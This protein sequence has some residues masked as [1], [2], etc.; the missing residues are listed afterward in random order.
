MT[1][2]WR[3]Q[4]FRN[5]LLLRFIA[6]LAM[7]TT[8]RVRARIQVAIRIAAGRTPSDWLLAR[9]GYDRA[10]LASA[11]LGEEVIP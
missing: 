3:L 7:W 6:E 8:P 4:C 5:R 11:V 1:V 2:A 9:A 10:W